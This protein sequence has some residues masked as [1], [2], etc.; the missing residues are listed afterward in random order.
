MA[1]EAWLNGK[2]EGFAPVVMP[3]AHA[4]VQAIVDLERFAA[5]LSN[6]ELLTRPNASP[7]AAFHPGRLIKKLI[8][9]T[10]T[11][12]GKHESRTIHYAISVGRR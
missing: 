7:S 3:A 8:E 5:D 10:D 12:F 9:K 11:S 6:E 2:L 1:N 4:L